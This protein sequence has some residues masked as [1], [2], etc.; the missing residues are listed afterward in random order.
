MDDKDLIRI[1]LKR[2]LRQPVDYATTRGR[3]RRQLDKILA[4]RGLEYVVSRVLRMLTAA[5]RK[6]KRLGLQTTTAK[7]RREDS[8]QGTIISN[9]HTDSAVATVVDDTNCASQSHGSQRNS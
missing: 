2:T 8:Q 4:N 5:R 9:N 7:P 1:V 3:L 6:L